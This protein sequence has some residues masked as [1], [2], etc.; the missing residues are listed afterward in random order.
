MRKIN[1]KDDF[2]TKDSFRQIRGIVSLR[3]ADSGKIIF[4]K[5]NMIVESG[6]KFI[7]GKVFEDPNYSSFTISKIKFGKGIDIVNPEDEDLKEEI[8]FLTKSIVPEKDSDKILFN[9]SLNEIKLPN[10]KDPVSITELGLFLSNDNNDIM[11]SRLVF[12]PVYLNSG[13]SYELEY[14]VYF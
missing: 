11:F 12:E 2:N 3:D 4:R 5:E 6:R 13:T 8:G 1:L 7:L 9:I 10:E 14:N